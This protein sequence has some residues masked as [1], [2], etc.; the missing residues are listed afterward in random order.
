MPKSGVFRRWGRPKERWSAA[1]QRRFPSRWSAEYFAV[2]WVSLAGSHSRWSMPLSTPTS[3]SPSQR[4]LSCRPNPP[5]GVRSSFA[6]VGLTVVTKSVKTSPPLRKF[7]LPYHSSC[8][9]LKSS[10][11]RPTSGM[12]S[13]GKCP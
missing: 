10:H 9:Q 11:G 6:W 2:I 13:G 3:R 5:P 1:L 4:K 7:T 12:V 8:R